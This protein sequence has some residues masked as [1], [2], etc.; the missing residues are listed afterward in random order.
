MDAAC[1]EQLL[2]SPHRLWEAPAPGTNVP[3]PEGWWPDLILEH[4]HIPP[5][6]PHPPHP[7]HPFHA[8]G[9]P[10]LSC[11]TIPSFNSSLSYLPSNCPHQGLGSRGVWAFA[12]FF[13]SCPFMFFVFMLRKSSFIRQTDNYPPARVFLVR[14]LM[15]FGDW[16]E[17]KRPNFCFLLNFFFSKRPHCPSPFPSM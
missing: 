5:R 7:P 3:C 4:R 1:S 16:C 13:T 6:P 8:A 17:R 11:W 9:H 2:P 15:N 10:A 14:F 12:L